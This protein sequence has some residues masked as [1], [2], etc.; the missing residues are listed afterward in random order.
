MS[1]EK[2]TLYVVDGKELPEITEEQEKALFEALRFKVTHCSAIARTIAKEDKTKAIEA[3]ESLQKFIKGMLQ[4]GYAQD[5][6]DTIVYG[7]WRYA[8]SNYNGKKVKEIK[9]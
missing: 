6:I 3:Q 2:K 8:E 9:V 1:E 7:F 5:R 4:K